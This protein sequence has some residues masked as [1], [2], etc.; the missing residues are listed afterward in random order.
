MVAYT[1]DESDQ[2]LALG[3]CKVNR[4]FL[5]LM[6]TTVSQTRYYKRYY[7]IVISILMSHKLEFSSSSVIHQFSL[8]R[9]IYK[10]TCEWIELFAQ[11][12]S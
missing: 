2:F 5:L 12:Y 9:F 6:S 3:W 10:A 7:K 8:L 1:A 4:V 11:G